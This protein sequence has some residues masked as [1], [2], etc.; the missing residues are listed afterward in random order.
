G[1]S[2][3]S[4]LFYKICAIVEENHTVE[5]GDISR[6]FGDIV[7]YAPEIREKL[8]ED[9]VDIA[10]VSQLHIDHYAAPFFGKHEYARISAAASEN[11]IKILRAAYVGEIVITSPETLW[12]SGT[13]GMALYVTDLASE[14]AEMGIAVT[15]VTPLFSDEK[16]GIFRKFRPRDTGRTITVKFG[17]DG[18]GGSEAAVAKIYEARV[19]KVRIL[20]LENDKYFA[21]IKG[22][23]PGVESAYN[24]SDSFK[25]RF[26]RMLSLGTLLAAREMNIHPSV[27]QT[28][29]WGTAYVKAYLEGRERID[30][31]AQNLRQ[32][33]HLARTRVMSVTHN[34]HFGYQGR[35]GSGSVWERDMRITHDLGMYPEAD[36][37]VVFTGDDPLMI[38]PTYTAVR[39]ADFTRDVSE[40]HHDRSIDYRYEWEMGKLTGLL[41]EKDSRGMYDG[42]LNGLGLVKRQRDFLMAMLVG[43]GDQGVKTARERI[44]QDMRAKLVDP[45]YGKDTPGYREMVENICANPGRYVR[46]FL[47]MGHDSE[48]RLFAKFFFEFISPVQKERLQKAV[49]LE[50]DQGKFVYSMLHR[51]GEQKGHQLMLAEIWQRNK[52]SELRAM[53]DTG[54]YFW[55]RYESYDHNM[56]LSDKDRQALET[57]AAANGRGALRAAEVAM[58]LNPDI[59]FIVAGSVDKGSP[60]DTG[61][62]DIAERFPERFIYKPEFIKS[63]N[64]LYDLIYSGSTR[65]GMPS[66]Y[67][68]AGLSNQEA[69]AYGVPR[70]LSRRDGLKDGEIKVDGVEEG[71][72]PYNPVEWFASLNRNYD[73]FKNRPAAEWELH[74]QAIIQDNRWL[75]KA[76]NYIELYRRISEQ[77]PIAELTVLEVAAAIHR[78]RVTKQKD[79]ADELIK[80]GF[81]AGE[82]IA[83][84]IE[85]MKRSGNRVLVDA[86]ANKHI[87]ALSDIVETHDELVRKLLSGAADDASLNPDV[88]RKFVHALDL[89]SNR[90]Q[91]L[92][93]RSLQPG[94]GEPG[95]SR[96]APGIA[97]TYAKFIQEN[98]PLTGTIANKSREPVLLRVPVEVIDIIGF[99]VAD[100]F[101]RAF[102]RSHNGIV[103]LFYMNGDDGA[104]VQESVY[105]ILG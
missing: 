57:Y 88:Q 6:I 47:E 48:R 91:A 42:L 97:R 102:E 90:S 24:G 83:V 35:I 9:L 26:S 39:T 18:K 12:S 89:V 13:G 64:P 53:P 10:V 92:G 30:P 94:S 41:R 55:S 37:G 59:Q 100:G 67:E 103:E 23:K 58:I 15:V 52:P 1:L 66:W 14:L 51:T 45:E 76:K 75:N 63:D 104:E 49:G 80:A 81:T 86:L 29:D 62:A 27:I 74:Y 98:K 25:L 46:S 71:F 99:H 101:V 43:G 44:K 40:G 5:L 7:Y 78:A 61:L 20:Y 4:L 84:V 2:E 50:A 95:P 68:P 87:P 33:P 85:C 93:D 38:N 56:R 96:P 8:H 3:F 69:A 65:F 16:A 34:L 73:T 70:H 82:A 22:Q 28:N 77:S 36:G 31:A 105:G 32:D 11:A 17:Q 54:N 60:F 79:A 19:N 72:E 21:A